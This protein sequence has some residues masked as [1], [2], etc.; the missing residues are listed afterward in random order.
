MWGD[1]CWPVA[2]KRRIRAET[3]GA[4]NPG[5]RRILSTYA[6]CARFIERASVVSLSSCK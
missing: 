5:V 4:A 3:L 2:Y 6:A 1:T